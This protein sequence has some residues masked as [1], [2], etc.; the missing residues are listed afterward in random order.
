MVRPI[1]K[2]WNRLYPDIIRLV[3]GLERLGINYH[4]G[5]VYYEGLEGNQNA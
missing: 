4:D 3:Q 1:D 5:E 2:R